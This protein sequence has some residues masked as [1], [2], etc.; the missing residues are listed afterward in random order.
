MISLFDLSDKKTV[1]SLDGEKIT[2][3]TT[4]TPSDEAVLLLHGH[5]MESRLCLPLALPFSDSNYFILPDM[6]GFGQSSPY[7]SDPQDVLAVF[8]EDAER[9]LKANNVKKVKIVAISVGTMVAMEMIKR[10]NTDIQNVLLIDHS[11]KPLSSPGRK[12]GFC[13]K[14]QDTGTIEKMVEMFRNEIGY[15][16]DGKWN[17]RRDADYE[18]MSAAFKKEYSETAANTIIAGLSNYPSKLLSISGNSLFRKI[19]PLYRSWYTTMLIMA[20]YIENNYDYIRVL[21]ETKIPYDVYWA[22]D[23]KMFG[24]DALKDY[25]DI[26]K[27]NKGEIKIF[28]GGHDFFITHFSDFLKEFKI[29]LDK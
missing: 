5:S 17:Y 1:T 8:A 4:G 13:P 20:S 15:F 11:C 9:I 12:T 7:I 21:S 6:R 14:I 16:K 28:E 29:F 27:N 23:T 19:N 25:E 24:P 3:R 18:K 2:Y 10:G 26:Q 22:K